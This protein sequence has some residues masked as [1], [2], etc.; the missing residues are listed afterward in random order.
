M[1]NG[2][3]VY[4]L[5]WK[6]TIAGSAPAVTLTTTSATAHLPD[7]AALG[8]SLAAGNNHFWYVT[9]I[10][11]PDL[12]TAARVAGVDGFALGMGGPAPGTWAGMAA[13]EAWRFTLAP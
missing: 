5:Q 13:G 2:E 6:P 8:V 1:E 12:A 9:S 4:P 3:A 10:D 11:A 7:V